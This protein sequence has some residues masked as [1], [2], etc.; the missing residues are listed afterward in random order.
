MMPSSSSF[1]V[2]SAL[3][4][5]DQASSNVDIPSE[6]QKPSEDEILEKMEIIHNEN[7]RK[8]TREEEKLQSKTS[9]SRQRRKQQENDSQKKKNVNFRQRCSEEPIPQYLVVRSIGSPS[10]GAK[11]FFLHVTKDVFSSTSHL[12]NV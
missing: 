11:M 3:P 8:R 1:N 6:G 7:T 2:L 9:A 10:I 5:D 4:S 12:K